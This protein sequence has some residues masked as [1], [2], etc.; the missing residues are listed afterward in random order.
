MRLISGKMKG[1][2]GLRAPSAGVLRHV[3][4][5]RRWKTVAARGLP[6]AVLHMSSLEGRSEGGGHKAVAPIIRSPTSAGTAAVC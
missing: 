5:G 6:S 1:C 3:P 2:G 4:T